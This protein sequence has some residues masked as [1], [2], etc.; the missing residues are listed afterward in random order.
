MSHRNDSRPVHIATSATT[1]RTYID[2]LCDFHR[3]IPL[4][5][6]PLL[7]FRRRMLAA[8]R[9]SR[10]AEVKSRDAIVTVHTERERDTL[11]LGE[12][13]RERGRR[14][15]R[16]KKQ[17]DFVVVALRVGRDLVDLVGFTV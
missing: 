14:K 10:K 13:E 11:T 8:E 3:T 6:M 7:S 4:L 5:P 17:P 12:R 9:R 15:D 16:E 1:R 2:H